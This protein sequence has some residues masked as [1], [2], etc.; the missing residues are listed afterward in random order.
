[1]RLV[2]SALLPLVC[3]STVLIISVTGLPAETDLRVALHDFERRALLNGMEFLIFPSSEARL[4]FVLMVANGAAFDPID[5][6]GVTQIM[7]RM[8]LEGA[9]DRGGHS[10]LEAMQATGAELEVRVDWD[11]IYF[12][13]SAPAERLVETLNGL[14]EMIVQPQF[15]EEDFTR[16]RDRLRDHLDRKQSQMEWKTEEVFLAELF[17]GNPYE[18]TVLGTPETLGNITLVDVKI[19]HRRLFLPNQA[20]LAV[21]TS[22]PGE[23]LFSGLSRRWGAWVRSEP[24]PFTFRQAEVTGNTRILLLDRDVSESVLRWGFLSAVR[25]EPISYPLQVLEQYLTLSMPAWAAKVSSSS[26]IRGAARLKTRR[27]PGYLQASLPAPSEQLVSYVRE[28]SKALREVETGKLDVERFEEA[29]RLAFAEFRQSFADPGSRL[30]SLLDMNLHG[31]GLSYAHQYGLRLDRV[32]PQTFRET[33]K[34]HVEGN[35]F[36]MV[37][38]GPAEALGAPLSEFGHIEILK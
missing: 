21:Y 25:G 12:I 11:A 15:E 20:Q 8:V 32:T 4:P 9:K 23:E 27:M 18:H 38:A 24:A 33:V 31:L 5:K 37:V 16:I 29:K 14:G 13:G 26:Q 35:G 34:S 30:L 22:L 19:Q 17:R 3:L 36:L 6:W 1:M 28:L 7:S 2:R 10:I